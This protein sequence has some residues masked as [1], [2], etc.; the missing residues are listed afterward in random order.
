MQLESLRHVVM[1]LWARHLL[2]PQD[3][4]FGSMQRARGGHQMQL[5]SLRHVVVV[6]WARHLLSPQDSRFG[7][8]QRA[9]GGHQ[10][11][12]LSALHVVM[13]LWARHL[14]S[15]QDS[16][17]GSMQRA[18]G[19]HQMQLGSA[20]QL[21]VVLCPLQAVLDAWMTAAIVMTKKRIALSIFLSFSKVV[22]FSSV[23]AVFS[24]LFVQPKGSSFTLGG[25]QS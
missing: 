4:R 10:M 8:M 9:R 13:V 25:R 12:L 24:S 18:R 16:R 21:A 19:G 14:L 5:E 15:P 1:V 3:S 23:S 11:Q 22:R 2:S 6:L 17:F 20:A 7:S